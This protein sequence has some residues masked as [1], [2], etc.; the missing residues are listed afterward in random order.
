MTSTTAGR[1]A[2]LWACAALTA[3][4]GGGSSSPT[5]PPPPPPPTPAPLPSNPTIKGATKIE[6]GTTESFTT[7]VTNPAGLTFSWDFGDGSTGTGTAPTH[8]YTLGGNYHVALKISNSAN[9]SVGAGFDLQAAHY[10]NVQGLLCS[11][12]DSGG[13]CWQDVRLTGHA[14]TEAQFWPGGTTGWA[15]GKSGTLVRT[16]DQGDTWTLHTFKAVDDLLALN[17]RTQYDGL[18]LNRGGT[19]LHSTD[20]G[21]N[22]TPVPANPS[23]SA[24]SH[25]SIPA[26]DTTKIVVTDDQSTEISFDAGTSWH[27]TTMRHAFV[28][29]ADCWSFTGNVTKSVGCTAAP[30]AAHVGAPA[31]TTFFAGGTI[32]DGHRIALLGQPPVGSAM[33]FVTADS[34]TTWTPMAVPFASG[35]TLTLVDTKGDAWY[36]DANHA[37]WLSTDWGS[38]YVAAPVPADAAAS[39]RAGL[40]DDDSTLFYARTGHLALSSDFGATFVE[41][42]SPEPTTAPTAVTEM[43]VYLWDGVGHAVVSY[44]GRFHV[45]HDKGVHW[46]QVLGPDPLGVWSAAPTPHAPAL[47]FGDAK[48]GTLAMASGLVQATADGG[49]TW[50]R[51]AISLTQPTAMNVSVAYASPTA[52]WMALDGRLWASTN[53]GATWAPSTPAAAITRVTLTAWGDAQHGWIAKPTGVYATTDGGASWKAVSLGSGFL[54]GDVVNGMSFENAQIG[55]V[56]L[57][58]S[59]GAHL[60]RTADGGATWSEKIASRAVG[61]V[62]HTGAK[63]FWFNGALPMHSADEGLTWKT[64]TPP[65]SSLTLSVFGGPGTT[66]YAFDNLGR[67]FTSADAGA[68]WTNLTL[69]A[70][71]VTGAGFALDPLTVWTVTQ[72]GGVLATATAAK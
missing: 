42:P 52:A 50:S 46:T 9:K 13:W 64:V 43:R 38:T 65:V 39:R 7:S 30:V 58:R 1:L 53:G 72:Y 3:C 17:F 14:L 11:E 60:L 61:T 69:S 56:S 44:D 2:A 70:D 12:A 25:P 31:G 28:A 67:V 5:P 66:V 29:G 35:G 49:R 32:G 37:A 55:V 8:V 57:T 33:S 16:S 15:I 23:A 18:V 20:G 21:K 26:Y 27:T 6:A 36:V 71:L 47:A 34:G 19:L 24:P 51:T 48:H 68:T 59:N 10:T 22:W 45:T 4:G 40:V 62:S 54:A 41:M 63:D